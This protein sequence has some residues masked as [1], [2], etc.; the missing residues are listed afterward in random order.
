MPA[1]SKDFLKHQN[2]CLVALS[3]PF[4]S[5]NKKNRTGSRPNVLILLPGP[6]ASKVTKPKSL[7]LA[8]LEGNLEPLQ[9]SSKAEDDR[10]SQ[11]NTPDDLHDL[12]Q[13]PIN[14]AVEKFPKCPKAEGRH[15]EHSQW[16]QSSHTLV[17]SLEWHY[18]TACLL[19]CSECANTAKW[20]HCNAD[21]SD[22]CNEML[23]LPV[24]IWWLNKCVTLCS[25]I[26]SC[27][28]ANCKK[29]SGGGGGYFL[30]HPVLR[31]ETEH[32]N[33]T[34]QKLCL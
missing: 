9:A 10:W 30:L 23:L 13:E 14:K 2:N 25:E 1:Y 32:N 17:L 33:I 21:N 28:K 15:L 4:Y 8:C 7:K 16:L 27:S 20:Q 26:S 11:G 5:I 24:S 29:F 22:M 12:H 6:V 34:M 3:D 19:E 31:T 18:L